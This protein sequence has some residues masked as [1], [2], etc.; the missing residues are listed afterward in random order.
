MKRAEEQVKKIENSALPDELPFPFPA[1]HLLAKIHSLNEIA[2]GV[3][4]DVTGL[5][6]LVGL[7]GL[8]QKVRICDGTSEN[9]IRLG[10]FVGLGLLIV[11]A[12]LATY[13]LHRISDFKVGFINFLCDDLLN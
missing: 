10:I 7:K 2:K 4:E 3:K 6:R 11:L 13:R 12:A 9:K 1:K 8:V 5:L